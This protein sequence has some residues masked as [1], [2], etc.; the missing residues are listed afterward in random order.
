MTPQGDVRTLGMA[1]AILGIPESL[2][3]TQDNPA[4]LTLT[5]DQPGIQSGRQWLKAPRVFGPN[6]RL[7]TLQTQVGGG[8]Q[9]WGLSFGSLSRQIDQSE[10]TILSQ[11]ALYLGFAR[12]FSERKL[13][14]GVQLLLH[15]ADL[16]S[17]LESRS[18]QAPGIG[19]GIL[20]RFPYRILAGA[21]FHTGSELSLEDVRA[22]IHIPWR[23]GIGLGFAPNRALRLGVS[24]VWV[25]ATSQARLLS[26]PSRA[27]G[28]QPQF[29]PRIG[30]SY[31]LLDTERADLQI[32]SGLY[33]E[34][35][36]ITGERARLH[37]TYGLNM[38]IWLLN[39]NAGA[40]RAEQFHNRSIYVGLNVV[41]LLQRFEL[42]PTLNTLPPEGT[43]KLFP[44]PFVMDE[45]GLA[46]NLVED[47]SNSKKGLSLQQATQELPLRLEKKIKDLQKR[48]PLELSG[49]L[50]NTVE[51]IPEEVFESVE[52]VSGEVLDTLNELPVH[53]PT[54]MVPGLN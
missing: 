3:A 39:I 13:S 23:M 35:S 27:V 40:D 19:A 20:Y 9:G 5:L 30:L 31:S 18:G 16:S 7:E 4:G 43:R 26:D 33:H 21:S 15:S 14:L 11:Q 6:T 2:M 1:G 50:L 44:N 46:L 38:S 22:P 17:P 10:D 37:Y 29:Q 28:A 32:T 45:R 36:R 8:Y 48:S 42:L 24:G 51:K 12:S 52:E 54:K 53:L 41:K 25:G 47:P 49:D 34:S